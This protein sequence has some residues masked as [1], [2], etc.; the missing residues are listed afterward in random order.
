MGTSWPL[1][2]DSLGFKHLSFNRMLHG[3]AQM[4]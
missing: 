2:Q 1:L 3:A 4:F